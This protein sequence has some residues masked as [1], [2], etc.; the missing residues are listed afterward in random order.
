MFEE[1]AILPLL[2]AIREGENYCWVASWNA[3]NVAVSYGVQ[4]R[5]EMIQG[6]R[7][8]VDN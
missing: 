5:R 6:G 3:R 1:N 4:Q 8:K 7:Q 2:E